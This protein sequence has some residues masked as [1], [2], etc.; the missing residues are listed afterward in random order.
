MQKKI[1]AKNLNNYLYEFNKT[2]KEVAD[3]IGVS[4]QTFNTWCQGIALPRMGKVQAL[5]DYFHINKVDL[6]DEKVQTNTPQIIEYYDRLNDIGKAEAAKRVR[7][8]TYLPEYQNHLIVKAAHNDFA[9]DDEEQKLIEEDLK[10]LENL[11][12]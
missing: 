2:Q 5:A 8:L 10:D 11:E 1:F 12:D 7:E 6:I 9:N 3:A 4:P